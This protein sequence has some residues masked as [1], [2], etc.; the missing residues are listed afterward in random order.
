MFLGHIT[1]RQDQTAVCDK[2]RETKTLG[3]F[4]GATVAKTEEVTW[5]QKQ[6]EKLHSDLKTLRVIKANSKHLVELISRKVL[7]LTD[8]IFKK[9]R[10]CTL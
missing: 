8:P 9:C 5:L 6:T 10:F 2:L 4:F 7:L 3:A 1:C